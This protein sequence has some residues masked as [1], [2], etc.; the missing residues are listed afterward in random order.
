MNRKSLF[1]PIY[2]RYILKK[3]LNTYSLYS[4]NKI[5]ETE[6]LKTLETLRNIYL[7]NKEYKKALEICNKILYLNLYDHKKNSRYISLIYAAKIFFGNNFKNSEINDYLIS[8]LNSGKS[9]E[10][11]LPLIQQL[12]PGKINIKLLDHNLFHGINIG[13]NTKTENDTND[14]KIILNNIVFSTDTDEINTLLSLLFNLFNKDLFL[15]KDITKLVNKYSHLQYTLL[16]NYLF[17]LVKFFK[18][19]NYFNV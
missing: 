16:Q 6:Y 4:K 14:L 1:Y 7:R 10:G 8:N 2:N 19:T 5:N 9:L 18:K 17:V 3:T 12:K 11:F 15:V 13:L